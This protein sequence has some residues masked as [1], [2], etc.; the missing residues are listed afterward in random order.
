M[1]IRLSARAWV[2]VVTFVLIGLLLIG[3]W[4]EIKHAWELLGRVNLWIL[5]LMIPLLALNYYASSESFMS[6]LRQKGSIG[7][8]SPLTQI[9]IALEFNFVNHALPS[10]GASG[11][12]YAT[13]RLS[14]LGVPVGRAAMA[15]VVRIATGFAAFFVLLAVSVLL[16]TIDG[17]VNRWIILISAALTG[18]MVT[19]AAVGWYFLSKDSRMH[20]A[21]VWLARNINR[22]A[23]W[24]TRNPS[25]TIVRSA[26]LEAYMQEVHEDYVDLKREKRR[27]RRPFLWNIVFI[28]VEVAIFVTAFWAFGHLVNPAPVLIA[29][30][31]G[32]IA[33]M[34]VLT[35]GG[36][37]AYEALMVSFLA[38]AGLSGGVA[39]AGVLLAR[40]IILLVILVP[41]YVLYQQAIIRYGKPR[42]N[43]ER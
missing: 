23:R 3:A 17:G 24:V 5:S 7:D 4:S 29:F 10:G 26:T 15:Q 27:L 12:S 19:A 36:S 35:P 28:L 20:R 18:L 6:Y 31:L 14:R 16:I 33:G 37:G 25:R 42:I 32:T 11:V 9:R 2:S 38:I 39:I 43:S 30:G 13:W 1:K 34:V 21:A 8:I 22:V 40:M 41:G